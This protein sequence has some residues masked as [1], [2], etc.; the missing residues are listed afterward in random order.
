MFTLYRHNGRSAGVFPS[1]LKKASEKFGESEKRPTSIV[2]AT[3]A[4]PLRCAIGEATPASQPP[5]TRH[6]NSRSN[7]LATCKLSAR[8]KLPLL[9]AAGVLR[10]VRFVLNFP[11]SSDPHDASIKSLESEEYTNVLLGRSNGGG[12]ALGMYGGCGAE[13][14]PERQ[15]ADQRRFRLDVCRCCS[16]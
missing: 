8:L 11:F 13:R 1:T 7:L 16:G 5:I 2:V 10:S 3:P 15:R 14:N 4:S 12:G 6:S 9:L